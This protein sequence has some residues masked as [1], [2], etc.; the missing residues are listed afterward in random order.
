MDPTE[1]DLILKIF[2]DLNI[3]NMDFDFDYSDQP[4]ELAFCY[5]M[6][7]LMLLPQEWDDTVVKQ[8]M[9]ISLSQAAPLKQWPHQTKNELTLQFYDMS[10]WTAPL[11]SKEALKKYPFLS[12][13]NNSDHGWAKLQ[14]IESEILISTILELIRDHDIPALPIHDSLIVPSETSRSVDE[15]LK[16]YFKQRLGINVQLE[17]SS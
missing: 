15:I 17:V 7:A 3:H 9:T 13:M 4:F 14:F 6:T 2:K 5:V 11:V 12:Y 16:K 10:K 1:E 8:W